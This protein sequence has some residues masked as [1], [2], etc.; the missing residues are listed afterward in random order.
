MTKIALSLF[1]LCISLFLNIKSYGFYSNNSNSN[2]LLLDLNLKTKL[3]EDQVFVYILESEI[4]EEN[5][6]K[7][8]D[9]IKQRKGV[10]SCTIDIISRKLTVTVV[11]EMPKNDID[12]IVHYIEHNFFK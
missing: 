8:I 3:S 1:L 6:V 4:T 9:F 11:P 5:S 7:V 10:N 12:G 2:F